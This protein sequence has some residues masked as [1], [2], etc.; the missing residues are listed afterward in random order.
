[1]RTRGEEREMAIDSIIEDGMIGSLADEGTIRAV[2]GRLSTR[3][4]RALDTISFKISAEMSSIS[5]LR[6]RDFQA[7]AD[8]QLALQNIADNVWLEV[9]KQDCEAVIL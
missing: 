7:L 8:R 1:M 5:R 4:L 6:S 9:L 2:L 3:K